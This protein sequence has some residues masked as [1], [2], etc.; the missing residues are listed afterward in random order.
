MLAIFKR[1]IKS[2][3]SS[4]IGYLVIGFFLLLSGLFLWV[5]KGPFNLLE[6]GFA[7]LTN[8]FRLA[9]WVLLFLIPAIAMRSFSE[10]RKLGTLELLF[11]K[12]LNL[13]QTVGGKFLDAL[14]QHS[15]FERAQI[16]GAVFEGARLKGAD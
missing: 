7:D 4:P 12:P 3:F 11:I 16:D 13:W 5:F 9:P 6:Y 1:E 14:L 8:F 15:D 10:E 2:F